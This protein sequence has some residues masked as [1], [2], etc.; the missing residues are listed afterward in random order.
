MSAPVTDDQGRVVQYAPRSAAVIGFYAV[1]IGLL[2]WLEPRTS[3]AIPSL[4]LLLAAILAVYLARYLTTRYVL[5]A[6]T[7]GALRLFGSRRVRLEEVRAI[8]L[9]NLR[10]IGSIGMFGTWGWRSRVFSPLLGPFETIHTVSSGLLVTVGAVPLFISPRDPT[11][12]GRELSRRARSWGVELPAEPPP[13][14]ARET[15]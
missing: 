12:F 10:D 3:F 4:P 9:A 13:V 8:E 1:L 6:E 15:A 14:G 7:L 5:D 11:A 2:L